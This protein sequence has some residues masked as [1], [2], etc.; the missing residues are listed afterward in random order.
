M[1]TNYSPEG[2]QL[3]QMK[4]KKS[5]ISQSSKLL[6]LQTSFKH[7]APDEKK[8]LFSKLWLGAKQQLEQKDPHELRKKKVAG[9]QA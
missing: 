9:N 7:Q 4:K 8:D 2:E 1:G 3:R 6:L 5:V